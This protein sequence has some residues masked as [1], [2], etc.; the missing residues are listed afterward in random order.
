MKPGRRVVVATLISQVG[1]W[2]TFTGLLQYVQTRFG[3]TATVGMFVAQSLPAL[4]AAR[5]VAQRIR[6][7]H[8]H[9]V[10]LAVQIALAALSASLVAGLST[11]W[12]LYLFFGLSALLRTVSSTLLLVLVSDWTATPA[13]KNS[14]FTA[15]GTAGSVTLA[16]SPAA[17][18][19][20]AAA[21]GDSWL[22]IADAVTFILGA[23]VLAAPVAVRDQ[24]DRTR[25]ESGAAP[26]GIWRQWL[27]RPGWDGPG[28]TRALGVWGW[29]SVV[30]AGV[31]AIELPVFTLVH[32]FDARGFGYG[33]ACYGV[34]GFV[35]F[36]ISQLRPQWDIAP[37][38]LA[39]GYTL[40]LAIWAYLGTA[41]AYVGFLTAGATYG[42]LSGKLRAVLDL[43]AKDEGIEHVALWAWV[44][45]VVLVSNL[46]VYAAAAVLFGVGTPAVWL[47][48][49]VIAA[50]AVVAAK[51]IALSAERHPVTTRL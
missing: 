6:P 41:G 13:E 47:S 49:A 38:R 35:A 46:V 22:F 51:C 34:G 32:H 45:Q 33:L 25:A 30:G 10:W 20:I 18:G 8:T 4:L 27:G 16:V 3:S 12:Y 26:V 1:N 28:I 40:G 21:F 5:G 43:A 24:R 29:F 15:M 17:G 14:T 23:L 39:A 48:V 37:V 44:N 50:A 2:L 19:V 7:H 11:L 31:N 42:L 36:S 9:R